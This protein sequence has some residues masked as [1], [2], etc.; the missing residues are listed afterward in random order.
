MRW[1][2][3][4]GVM[5]EVVLDETRKKRSEEYFVKGRT[6]GTLKRRLWYLAKQS[7]D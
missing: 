7:I 2:I 3:G 4:K 1:R 5:E 6:Q